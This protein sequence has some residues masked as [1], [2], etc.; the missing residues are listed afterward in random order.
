MS[1]STHSSPDFSLEV[2]GV[3]GVCPAGERHAKQNIAEGKIPVFSCEGPCIRGEIARLAANM[4]AEE[5]P[6]ARSCYAE[7]FLVPHSSMTRWMREA[8]RVVIIDGCF[9]KCHGR[10][11]KNLIDEEKM[12]HID[13]LPLHRKYSDVFLMDDVPEAERKEVA[14]EVADKILAMLEK[15]PSMGKSCPELCPT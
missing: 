7:T 10:V 2:D 13:A 5:E 1:K 6:Y 4:V 9:L 14:R 15:G 11:F 3:S 12:I 8:E